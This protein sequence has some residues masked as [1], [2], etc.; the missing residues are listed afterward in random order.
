MSTSDALVAVAGWEMR[1][2]AGM[3]L[4]LESDAPSELVILAFEEFLDQTARQ[5]SELR[6]LAEAKGAKYREVHVTRE[7]V[8]LWSKVR[9]T[10]SG[11]DWAER[12]VLIDISTMPREVIWWTFSCLRAARSQARYV[13]YKAKVYSQSWLTRDTAKPRLV[14]QHSGVSELGRETCL[15]LLSGFDTDRAAQLIQFF[16]PRKVL[17][18]LQSGAQFDNQIKNVEQNKQSM[19]RMPS[20]RFFDLD[21]FSDDHGLRAMEDAIASEIHTFNVVAT[22]L[23]P[24]P[25]AVALYRLQCNHPDIALAYAPSRQFNMEYSDGIGDALRGVLDR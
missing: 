13:Y 18:G 4:N 9:D 7:P 16:E 20:I 3:R 21:A 15:L 19:G 8:G 17:F 14:Y 25:S 23:G 11:P 22:S 10:F 12:S 24:K 5:R 6:V 1:F 2:G